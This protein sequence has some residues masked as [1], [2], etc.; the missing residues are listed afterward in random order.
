MNYI[1][2]EH[3]GT[4]VFVREDLK[5]KHRDYCL[6]YL[7]KKLNIEDREKNCPIASKLYAL[8]VVNSLTTP[9]FECAEFEE[10]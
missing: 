1:K 2:Y 4:P 5:G 3:H 7:C 9:V 10:K 8:D 6:C